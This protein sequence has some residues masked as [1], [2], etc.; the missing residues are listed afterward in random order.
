MKCHQ[1]VGLIVAL[2]AVVSMGVFGEMPAELKGSWVIDIDASVEYMKTSPRW[3]DADAKYLPS[4][5]KRMAQM[6]YVFEEGAASLSFRGKALA[7]P[8]TLQESREDTYVFETVVKEQVVF[9]TVIFMDDETIN[10]R[11][12]SSDD[13]HY[14]LWQRGELAGPAGPSDSALAVEVMTE[15]INPPPLPVAGE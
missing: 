4:I 15:A 11:S 6:G 1:K 12:S 5:M 13:M 10:I 8:I 2:V 3:V 9:L 7:L 14:Y